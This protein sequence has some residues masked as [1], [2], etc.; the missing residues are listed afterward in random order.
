MS[1][2]ITETESREESLAKSKV[3]PHQFVTAFG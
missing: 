3:T 1:E 2:S